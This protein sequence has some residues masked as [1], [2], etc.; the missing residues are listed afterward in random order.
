M[1]TIC[2]YI[3]RIEQ[4]VEKVGE[5]VLQSNILRGA[6]SYPAKR[7]R[8]LRAFEATR[9]LVSENNLQVTDLIYPLF[10]VEGK[11]RRELVT[12]MPSIERLS[13][14]ELLKEVAEL[15]ELG[16]STVMLFPVISAAKKSSEAS[17]AWNSSGL[18][19]TAVTALRDRF[20]ELLVITDVALDPFT[21]N[22]QDGLVNKQGY[23]DNDET[24]AALVKQAL[25]HASAGAHMV[26]PSDMMDGRVAMIRAALEESGY[27]NTLILAYSVKYAS[28]FYGPFRDAVGSAASLGSGDKRS[29]QMDSANSDEALWEVALDINE[30][31]DIIMVKPGLLCLDVL[32]RVKQTFH[33]PTFVY[34]VSGE[35]SMLKAAALNGWLDEQSA[36]LETLL[37]CKRAGADAIV[38]YYAKQVAMWLQA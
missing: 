27:K 36:V 23:V 10:I 24:V 14:D 6:G 26:A 22:G 32:S 37:T 4:T 28:A 29:Y 17:E 15:L 25:S 19:Q 38:T 2:D 33:I 1:D 9:R 11:A 7:L 12:S 35:Y 20:P 3:D 18:I 31:A 21:L 8:R 13:I 5:A 16:L 30:G 34:Q